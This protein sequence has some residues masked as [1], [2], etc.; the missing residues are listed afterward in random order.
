MSQNI[1]S[2][3][4][5]IIVDLNC[6]FLPGGALAI[7][8]ADA[9]LPIINELADDPV[10]GL[11]IATQDWHPPAH[12]SFAHWPPHCVAGT[13]GAELHPG[14]EADR[15]DVLIRKGFDPDADSYSGFFNE[16]GASNGLAEVLKTR[17]IHA[18]DIVG[19]ATDFCVKATAI[20]AA[21]RAHL[22]TRVLLKGCRAVGLTPT[23]ETE[24]IAAMR[25]SGV[26]VVVSASNDNIAH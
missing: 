9:I 26:E 20:D 7:E 3:K 24:A 19:L 12:A 23:A 1:H 5:L 14:L 10:Y 6:D 2:Q 8:G 13:S 21:S 15:I 25:A 16:H 22:K 4:A 18:V 11:V 17:G